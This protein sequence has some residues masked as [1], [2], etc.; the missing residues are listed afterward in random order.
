MWEWS[1]DL[2]LGVP[3]ECFVAVL[4]SGSG[5][6]SVDQPVS[7]GTTVGHW[8]RN[9]STATSG[10]LLASRGCRTG[11]R[12]S[13]ARSGSGGRSSVVGLLAAEGPGASTAESTS[14]VSGLIGSGSFI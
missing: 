3:Q 12:P 8:D 5:G 1:H 11:G 9:Q 4:T 13:V 7:G 14:G 6:L 2:A 10:L